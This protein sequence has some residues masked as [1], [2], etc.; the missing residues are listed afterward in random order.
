MY[1]EK[2]FLLPFTS[3]TTDNFSWALPFQI[4]SLHYQEF[5]MY[6]S[7]VS[8]VHFYLPY[9]SSSHWSQSG[10]LSAMLT[11]FY[12]YWK[13]CPSALMRLSWKISQVSW[14]LSGQYA[15][16]SNLAVPWESWSF[17]SLGPGG[18]IVLF[19]FLKSLRILNSVISQLQP[20]FYQPF[21]SEPLLSYLWTVHPTECLP[22]PLQ[23]QQR[24]G[25]RALRKLSQI[26]C[27]FLHCIR[28][29]V[30]K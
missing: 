27:T 8:F 11:Q 14:A 6:F 3:L 25:F 22:L 12:V 5:P 16:R 7:W 21:L 9:A 19:A 28:N 10:W 2:P 1:L 24:T 23:H 4:S 20:S 15:T 26:S 17:H 30:R 13:E 29:T 18:F